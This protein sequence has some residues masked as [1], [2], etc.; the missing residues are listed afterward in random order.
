M[1][2]VVPAD[3]RVESPLPDAF[4]TGKP[5]VILSER[6]G[7]VTGAE[8][9][10]AQLGADITSAY[11]GTREAIASNGRDADV[12]IAGAVEPFDAA[13]LDSLSRL[14]AVVRRGV[15]FDNVD[16][17][18]ATAA[19][20]LVANV[21]DASVD[22]V[23]DHAL[24]MLLALER[25]LFGL[26]ALVR[27]GASKTAPELVHRLRIGSR[28][29]S[30]LTLGIVGFGRIGGALAAK[31]GGI[32][33]R[34][35]VYDVAPPPAERL[36]S[37][38]LVSLDELIHSSDHISLHLSMSQ[39]NRQL[40]GAEQ[41]SQMKHDAVVVN[42][43]RGG[44]VDEAALV[45][46]IRDGAVAAAGLDVTA[47][48]PVDTDSVLLDSDLRDRLILTAHSAAWS[49]TAVT[50][51]TTGSVDAAA[52]L[53]RGELPRSVVNPAVLDSPKLRLRRLRMHARGQPPEDEQGTDVTTKSDRA[54]EGQ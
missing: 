39:D 12:I 5:L 19:G 44:V 28:R 10:L 30:H 34:V 49:Q 11:L 22:E 18:A 21:P 38:E 4:G 2:D 42:T 13:A 52:F 9:E 31:A 29:L 46:A 32:Y 51:L 3:S 25:R 15:G 27:D 7:P 8:L 23:S 6:L 45:S 26:D 24:A 33:R 48:E 47:S 40:I 20:I 17:E 53:L 43:A 41:I 16:I 35:L 37:C 36:G 50:A 54:G 14:K 1:H